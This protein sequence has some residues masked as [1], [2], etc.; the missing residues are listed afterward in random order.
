M[1]EYMRPDSEANALGVSPT[2]ADAGLKHTKID[3]APHYTP[4]LQREDWIARVMEFINAGRVYRDV[5]PA[6]ASLTFGVYAAPAIGLSAATGQSVTNGQTNYIYAAEDGTLTVSTSAFPST[7]HTPL[8]TIVAAAGD[9]DMIDDYTDNRDVRVLG[10]HRRYLTMTGADDADGT[11]TM[12]IQLKDASGDNLSERALVRVW[13]SDTAE[14]GAPATA[15]TDF[16]ASTGTVI[17]EIDADQDYDILADATGKVVMEIDDGADNTYYVSA[18]V[19][20][21]VYSGSA[22]ITGT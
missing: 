14:Y 20:G 19:D 18:E 15:G 4:L 2:Q 1:T 17:K 13:F 7:P 3:E 16:S 11:G 21:R 5:D 10:G 8:A 9:W 12:T 22:V 6:T